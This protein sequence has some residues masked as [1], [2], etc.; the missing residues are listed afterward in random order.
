MTKLQTTL[1]FTAASVFIA[2]PFMK[3]IG[4]PALK[5][6]DPSTSNEL[7]STILDVISAVQVGVT[8]GTVTHTVIQKGTVLVATTVLKNFYTM[9]LP[10][11]LAAYEVQS[12]AYDHAP[13]IGIF[14][15]GG[16][17][18]SF[19]LTSAVAA[20]EVIFDQNPAH[21][22]QIIYSNPIIAGAITS[23]NIAQTTN[24]LFYSTKAIIN[25]N[26]LDTELFHNS[27]GYAYGYAIARPFYQVGMIANDNGQA[28]VGG[29]LYFAA[30]MCRGYALGLSGT[31]SVLTPGSNVTLTSN[32]QDGAAIA[33]ASMLRTF[34]NQIVEDK[35]MQAPALFLK[36]IMPESINQLLNIMGSGN[37]VSAGLVLLE[38]THQAYKHPVSEYLLGS[39]DAGNS[40]EIASD[41]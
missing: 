10:A 39:S 22:A 28:F 38:I 36:S 18:S 13:T 35:N 40:T 6:L 34:L 1:A 26:N 2:D 33:S 4:C 29:A 8:L 9:V 27:Q 25:G 23:I 7:C 5:Y 14:L 24:M 20:G 16:L 31:G 32:V 11:G 19:E 3:H 37:F 21:K 41:L 17:K 12:F 30:P 15:I